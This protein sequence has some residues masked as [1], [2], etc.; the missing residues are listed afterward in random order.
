ME[1]QRKLGINHTHI[2]DC[3]LNKKNYK[4]AG[5]YIWKYV[6]VVDSDN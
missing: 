1:V 2:S 5:G 4:T 6:E 3:C